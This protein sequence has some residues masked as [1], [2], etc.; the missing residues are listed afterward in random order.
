M[1]TTL[2]PSPPKLRIDP[3][4]A[5]G[6]LPIPSYLLTPQDWAAEAIRRANE[7]L[8]M[9]ESAVFI[10][11]ARRYLALADRIKELEAQV[12]AGG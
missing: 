3:S 7:Y 2:R 12:E 10:T 1:T 6:I 11:E 4:V 5:K 8:G 9:P